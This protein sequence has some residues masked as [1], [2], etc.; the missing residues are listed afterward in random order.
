M[1]VSEMPLY[2]D[3]KF[4]FNAH[5]DY[6]VA[7]LITLV[8]MLARTA[9]LQCGLG[10][11]ALKAIYEGAI[12]PIL[13]YGA[14]IWV[15]AIR[16]SKNLTEYKR[17]QRLMNIKIAK[18]YRTVSYDASCVIAGV[19]PIQ[20]TIDEKVQTYI[21]TKINNVEYDAPLELRYWRHPAEIATVHE[22]ENSSMYTIE[23]YTDGSKIGNNVRAAGIIFVNGKLVHQLKFKLHGHCSNNQAEQIAILKVLK[24][25]EE[26][27]DWQE[28]EKRVAI[29]TDSKINL[30]LCTLDGLK[31]TRR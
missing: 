12:V 18:A 20:I 17:I 30:D 19:Q 31:D 15:E 28:N 9:K 14:P 10:H 1:S 2:F 4:N 16:K 23:V 25:L 6:T 7:K 8:N 21:A 22:V 26:L 13:T 27:Q 24:K 5:I 11:K 29:C 3:S